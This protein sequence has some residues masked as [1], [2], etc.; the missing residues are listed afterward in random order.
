MLGLF[1]LQG[2]RASALGKAALPVFYRAGIRNFSYRNNSE[3]SVASRFGC[4]AMMRN[5]RPANGFLY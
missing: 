3:L 5:G 1:S 2:Y 4:T